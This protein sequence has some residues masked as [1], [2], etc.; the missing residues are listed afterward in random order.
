MFDQ[1]DRHR[2]GAREVVRAAIVAMPLPSALD[3]FRAAAAARAEAVSR[4]PIDEAPRPAIDRQIGRR[5]QLHQ[6]PRRRLRIGRAFRASRRDRRE[7]RLA[8]HHP[9]E[10][11]L[12][13][14]GHIS[15]RAPNEAAHIVHARQQPVEQQH[16]CA[17]VHQAR[18]RFLI[19][20]DMIRPVERRPCES[21]HGR[22]GRCVHQ[23]AFFLARMAAR[24][25]SIAAMNSSRIG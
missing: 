18:Q 2:I 10:H 24:S 4:V 11:Q 16:P 19:N 20:A 22:C 3:R 21:H 8:V 5:E 9:E 15:K 1:H 23:A 12:G 14:L 13:I 25:A 17:P 6:L 7:M